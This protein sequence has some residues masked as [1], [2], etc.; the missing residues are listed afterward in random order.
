M[1][2]KTRSL[3][4]PGDLRSVK[5][6]AGSGHQQRRRAVGFVPIVL[7]KSFWPD[8]RIFLKPLMRC[9]RRY[10]GPHRFTQK[11]PRSFVS[12]LRSIAVAE[13]AENQLLREFRRRSIFDFCNTICQKQTHALQQ[14]GLFTRLAA[15]RRWA[16]FEC[17]WLGFRGTTR[18]SWDNSPR[19]NAGEKL[20]LLPGKGSRG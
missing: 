9:A 10:E 20:S 8:E 12:V 19:P 3:P 15:I 7:K 6:A 1:Q 2:G 4:P 14:A 5:A 13:S 18:C 17:R 16:S 11:R